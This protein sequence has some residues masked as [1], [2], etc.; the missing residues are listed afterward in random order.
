MDEEGTPLEYDAAKVHEGGKIV[1][2][3]S[4]DNMRELLDALD[5]ALPRNALLKK[6]LQSRVNK[7]EANDC[8]QFQS[9]SRG[10]GAPGN[11]WQVWWKRNQVS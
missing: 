10:Q 4:L 6:W 11:E 3:A 2:P 5:S 7:I 1:M 8:R 9:P